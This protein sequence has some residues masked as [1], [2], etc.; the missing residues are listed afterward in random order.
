MDGKKSLQQ[1]AGELA[2]EFNAAPGEIEK[3]VLGL[4]AE[5]LKRKMFIE[6]PQN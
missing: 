1:I 6:A 5:L 2:K 4:S 3:D